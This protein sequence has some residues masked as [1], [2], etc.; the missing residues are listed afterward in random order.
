MSNK[1]DQVPFSSGWSPFGSGDAS[2]ADNPEPRCPC[3]LLLDTSGS[4]EGEPI[5]SLNAGL[6]GFK[7]ELLADDLAAKRAE[8]ALV[9]FGPVRVE[10]DFT[11]VDLFNPP[12]LSAHGDT[13]MGAAIEQALSMV[14]DRKAAYRANGISYYRPWIFLITDGAPTD[15]WAEAARRVRE[16]EE[17]QS[18][19][20]FAVGVGP[21]ARL[22]TLAKISRRDPL[23]LDGL[24]FRDLFSWLSRSL[25]TVYRSQLGTQVA[26]PPPSG[27]TQV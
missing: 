5:A 14:A 17:K 7:D 4:M 13:P 24:R 25:Q 11:T 6:R 23:K 22:D 18:F 21:E 19:A 27:W 20:F 2:F 9:S 1:Y 8:V 15:E 12:S 26:L 16:G 10:H 3:V